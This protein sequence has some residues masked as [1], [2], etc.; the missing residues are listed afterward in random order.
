M[1]LNCR[2]KD[3]SAGWKFYWYK[4]VLKPSD[5]SYRVQQLPVSSSGTKQDS[6]IVHGQTHAA[7]Y[8]CRLG[9]GDPEF[10][11]YYSKPKFVWSS[12]QCDSIS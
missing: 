2:V 8:R 7:E 12:G 11:S 10:Y 4:R 6:Y 9:R 1:T 5:D 3:P